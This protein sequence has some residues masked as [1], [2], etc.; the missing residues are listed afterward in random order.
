MP[1]PGAG[2]PS[3]SHPLQKASAST[4]EAGALKPKPC[5]QPA[6]ECPQFW[7]DRAAFLSSGVPQ[8]S[9]QGV[10]APPP[11][12]GGRLQHRVAT[13][14]GS[15]ELT[16]RRALAPSPQPPP[17]S[18]RWWQKPQMPGCRVVRERKAAPSPPQPNEVPPAE[19]NTSVSKGNSCPGAWPPM[20]G[21]L[22]GH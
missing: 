1:A 19:S 18:C 10:R 20:R 17:Q 12:S 14:A 16:Q 11:L 21:H 9:S 15:G 8:G 3:R 22:P 4:P 7:E 13:H 5:V 2:R 6:Q